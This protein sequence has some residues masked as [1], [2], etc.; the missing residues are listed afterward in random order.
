[1][2]KLA[3]IAVLDIVL[4]VV[5][6]AAPTT[7]VETLPTTTVAISQQWKAITVLVAA[8]TSETTE[9][10]KQAILAVLHIILVVVVSAAATTVVKTLATASVAIS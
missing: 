1:M 7:A 3:T 6:S 8:E 4:E 10:A 2:A 5:E 9:I